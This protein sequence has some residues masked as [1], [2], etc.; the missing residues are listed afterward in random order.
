MVANVSPV[1]DLANGKFT[2]LE[3]TLDFYCWPAGD[4]DCLLL[5]TPAGNWG[6]IDCGL[7]TPNPALRNAE[8]LWSTVADLKGFLE[9]QGV[10]RLAFVLLTHPENDHAKGLPALLSDFEPN[11]FLSPP[12]AL[13]RKNLAKLSELLLKQKASG[14]TETA[15][16]SAGDILW[17]EAAHNFRLVALGPTRRDLLAFA[18]ATQRL[19]NQGQAESGQVVLDET[20]LSNQIM[21]LVEQLEQEQTAPVIKGRPPYNRLSVVALAT[22]GRGNLLMGADALTTSWRTIAKHPFFTCEG[23]RVTQTDLRAQVFKVPHHGANDGIPLELAGVFLQ[24]GAI[25]LVS[26]SGHSFASP[27]NEILSGLT[28]RGYAPYCTGRSA[29]CPG[30]SVGRPCCGLLK[31]Q[32]FKDGKVPLV[33]NEHTWRKTKPV[34]C[35]FQETITPSSLIRQ[36]F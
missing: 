33:E 32:L 10:R 15:I 5:K 25:S 1:K 20:A 11:L 14:Q 6:L 17:Q 31:V 3:P 2:N 27:S 13:G 18:T 26:S 28:R 9:Q 30:R 16:V 19:L 8:K 34:M 12:G 29:W 22:Y 23:V 36:N 7:V 24:E 21:G 35:S 4:A